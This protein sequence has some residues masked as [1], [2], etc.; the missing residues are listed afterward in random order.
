MEED[1]CQYSRDICDFF[2]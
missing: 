2:C 1:Y